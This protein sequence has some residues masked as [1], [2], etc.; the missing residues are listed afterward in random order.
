MRPTIVMESSQKGLIQGYLHRKLAGIYYNPRD[1][2]SLGGAER[3]YKRA[4]HLGIK[5]ATR[6]IVKRF[7]SCES[8]YTLHRQIRKKFQRNH[9]H[10]QGIDDQWQAD[11]VDMQELSRYNSGTKYLLTVI[12][13]FS[14]FAWVLPLRKKSGEELREAFQKLFKISSPRLPNKLQTDKGKEFFNSK[15]RDLLKNSYGVHHFASWSDQKAAVVERF[16]RTLKS[17]MWRYFS[18]HQ[19]KKYLDVLDDLVHSYNSAPHRSIG[20]APASVRVKNEHDIA[21]RLYAPRVETEECRRRRRRRPACPTQLLKGSIVRISRGKGTFAKGYEPNWSDEHFRI[22]EIKTASDR[23]S[24]A[25]RVYKLEDESGEPIEGIFYE[26]EIQPIGANRF[27]IEK[28]IRKRAEASK[29]TGGGTEYL[30][31][32]RG[33]PTKFNSWLSERELKAYK[34][35]AE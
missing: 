17:R 1:P 22:R 18:Q 20:C 2:G 12:D 29:V 6:A 33:W 13:V 35:T 5:G 19:T 7:L 24:V 21:R 4:K 23:N 30:V 9:T 14:K 31:K 3:L 26:S 32:W 27:L 34:E 15:V 10:V 11:L 28:V 25:P 8:A 16:N